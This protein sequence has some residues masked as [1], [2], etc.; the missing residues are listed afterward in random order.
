MS[1]NIWGRL[2]L[3]TLAVGLYAGQAR[4]DQAKKS[5]KPTAD[6]APASA[7]EGT[8]APAASPEDMKHALALRKQAESDISRGEFDAAT[9]KLRKSLKIN[10]QDPDA[11]FLIAQCLAQNNELAESATH[12]RRFLELAPDDQRAHRVKEV[13]Q[14]YEEAHR[15]R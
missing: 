3:A 12:F 8:A 11:H 1:R 2:A 6:A 7:T 4:A 9:F 15:D 13:L 10:E 14:A 5:S